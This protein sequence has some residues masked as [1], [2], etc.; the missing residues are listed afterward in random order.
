MITGEHKKWLGI[1]TLF[2]PEEGTTILEPP[3]QGQGYW[4]GAPGVI[5]DDDRGR[6]YIYYRRRK[7]REMHGDVEI[8]R[9]YECGISES[10]D[11]ISFKEIWTAPK[12]SFGSISVERAALVKT[13]DGK[14]RLYIGYVAPEDR[15]WKIDM[16]EADSPESLDP[17]TKK[18][19]LDP[20][21]CG[22]E[23]VKDPYIL[24]V[25]GKYY[26]LVSYAT[27]P[28]MPTGGLHDTADIFNTGKTTS[29]TGLALSSDGVNFKWIADV[30]SP[31]EG[32][33][34]YAARATCVLYLPPVFNVFYDGSASVEEN[35]EERT[36]LAITF[37]LMNYQQVT[38]QAPLLVSPHA[39]GSLRY[40][41]VVRLGEDIYYY[42][43][44]ARPDGSHEL[45]VNKVG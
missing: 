12:S 24:I 6:F 32:W 16:V 21:D 22:C 26:M 41:D 29:R 17:E 39:S 2:D 9:G 4:V 19:V 42:Y 5:Y 28:K 8:G 36:G 11:G 38:D 18:L 10:A 15:K 14:Y 31:G 37:D 13:L 34:A 7:P 23:G 27:S 30:L 1:A 25:G 43:E 20:N 3:G 45:R 33:N 35:Y 44:Y 40:M